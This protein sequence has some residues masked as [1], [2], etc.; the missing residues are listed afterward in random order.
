MT[1]TSITFAILL[2]GA[3]LF[4]EYIYF[5]NYDLKTDLQICLDREKYFID[6]R[7]FLLD[8]IPELKPQITKSQLAKIIKSKYPS[9]HVDGL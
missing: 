2:S 7:F 9:E 8:L 3:F 4:S 5:E 6:E 1:K